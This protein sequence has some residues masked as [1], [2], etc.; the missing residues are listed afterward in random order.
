MTDTDTLAPDEPSAVSR[1]TNR[2]GLGRNTHRLGRYLPAEV[3]PGSESW[4]RLAIFA[5][6]LRVVTGVSLLVIGT[7]LVG[8]G[9]SLCLQGLGLI[10]PHFPEPAHET[11]TTGLVITMF[12]SAFTGLAVET[13]FRSTSL[14]ADADHWETVVT[15]VPALLVSLWLMERVEQLAIRLLPPISEVFSLVPSYLNEVGNRGWMAGIVALPLIW[16][17]L[18][19]GAPEFPFMGE[20]SPALLYACWMALVILSYQA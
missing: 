12:G 19:F 3:L 7:G 9:V 18:R 13:A 10:D 6:S 16:L 14:R 1:M 2:R 11:L 8:I 20:N 17:A 5:R 15:W 4:R